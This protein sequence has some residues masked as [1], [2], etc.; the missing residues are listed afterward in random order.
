M[1]TQ[2]SN[3]SITLEW[4]AITCVDENGPNLEYVISYVAASGG[5]E[6]SRTTTNLSVTLMDLMECTR[7]NISVATRNDIGV[8]ME[9]RDAMYTT[10]INRGK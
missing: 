3:D 9:T 10:T 7:Y 6:M 8:S 2:L 1:A 5:V 4:D